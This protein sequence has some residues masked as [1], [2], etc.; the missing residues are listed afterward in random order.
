MY[1]VAAVFFATFLLAYT[2]HGI[3]H[4]VKEKTEGWPIK[5]NRCKLIPDAGPCEALIPKYFY[6][7]E[8]KVRCMRTSGIR[9]FP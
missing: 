5:E 2:A 4:V 6:N 9:A 8:R 3:P 1:R 7:S